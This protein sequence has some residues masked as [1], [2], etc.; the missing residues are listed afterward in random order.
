M[1]FFL[2]TFYFLS[3]PDAFF[4]IVDSGNETQEEDSEDV[5]TIEDLD[6]DNE[7]ETENTPPSDETEEPE[8]HG[9]M[10]SLD[11][12]VDDSEEIE[13]SQVKD[14]EMEELKMPCSSNPPFPSS[15]RSSSEA[16]AGPPILLS[17]S[18]RGED[19]EEED[20]DEEDDD[21]EDD[22]DEEDDKEDDDEED[23]EDD[24]EKDG[25]I[26]RCRKREEETIHECS[27]DKTK[28]AML[29][30]QDVLTFQDVPINQDG[31]GYESSH[32]ISENI[33]QNEPMHIAETCSMTD[34]NFDWME[35]IPKWIL[36]RPRW[37]TN[38][39]AEESQSANR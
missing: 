17:P 3:N 4:E 35:A 25:D 21:K 16:I 37:S 13:Y 39:Y 15:P 2:S 30:N 22:A 7:T 24:E 9:N 26:S 31:H 6:G 8:P 34:V 23:D 14:N 29:T 36:P 27:H 18:T 5:I 33:R 12:T 38:S 32:L 1:F 11:D 20:D 28:G 10:P 19:D